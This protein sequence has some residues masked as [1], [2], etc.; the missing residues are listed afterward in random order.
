[1]TDQDNLRKNL[2]KIQV[3]NNMRE[4]EERE[5]ANNKFRFW[6]EALQAYANGWRPPTPEFPVVIS[7]ESPISTAAKL[8][9]MAKMET[10]PRVTH[11]VYTSLEGG[12]DKQHLDKD[13]NAEKVDVGWVSQDQREYLKSEFTCHEKFLFVRDGE[14][15]RG[16]T[17]V[18]SLIKKEEE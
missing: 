13:D 17:L 7:P 14:K 6:N 11:T 3:R 8:K 5:R 10:D 4:A 12:L 9:E 1:M 2:G 15:V 18:T 16:V